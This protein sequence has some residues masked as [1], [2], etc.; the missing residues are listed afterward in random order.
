MTYSHS[1]PLL[2]VIMLVVAV[3]VAATGLLRWLYRRRGGLTA[4]WGGALFVGLCWIAALAL[5]VHRLLH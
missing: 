1:D 4:G 5:I 3:S 2:W